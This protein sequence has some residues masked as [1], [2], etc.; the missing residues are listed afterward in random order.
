MQCDSIAWLQLIDQ[1]LGT[2][3]MLGQSKSFPTN[4]GI[5]LDKKVI[6][7]KLLDVKPRDV[8][9]S[10][11]QHM[12]QRSGGAWTVERDETGAHSEMHLD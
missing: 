9:S 11:S 8:S 3:P 6:P 12:I 7:G 1:G 4:S 5:E 10:I 2:Q